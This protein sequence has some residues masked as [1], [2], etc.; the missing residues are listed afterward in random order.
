MIHKTA[1]DTAVAQWGNGLAVGLNK[2]VA[3]VAG[4][5]DGTQV[6]VIAG[7][8][9][10]TVETVV[11]P[12]LDL[13]AM[14]ASFDPVRHGGEAMA[15]APVGREIIDQAEA[16]G[17]AVQVAGMMASQTADISVVRKVIQKVDREVD[18]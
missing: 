13:A 6:R 1:V 14:L 17:A 18:A 2:A 8:G 9:R 3:K 12:K 5:I 4:M 15:F 16:K 7:Y 11:A 10:I